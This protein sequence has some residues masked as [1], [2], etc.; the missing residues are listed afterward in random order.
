MADYTKQVN[1][2]IQFNDQST[3]T[4]TSQSWNFGDGT[5]STQQNPKKTYTS[6]GTYNLT[7]AST[8]SCG[9]GECTI[10]TI[11]ITSEPPPSKTN[12][13][14]IIAGVGIGLGLL[15]YFTKKK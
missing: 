14:L 4:P 5:T 9:T 8:N 12:P 13:T 1:T 6:I 11:K 3:N 10:K 7:H 2:E 15:Y